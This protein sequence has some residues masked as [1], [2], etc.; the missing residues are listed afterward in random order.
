MPTRLYLQGPIT[1]NSPRLIDHITRGAENATQG[2]G[3]FAFATRTGAETLLYSNEINQ[4]CQHGTFKL[5]VGI[6]S[7]TTDATLDY[8]T[9]QA[10]S[11]KGL[12]V[13]AFNNPSNALFHPKFIHFRASDRHTL[14]SGS[15]NLTQGGLLENFENFTVTRGSPDTMLKV[16]NSIDA[17]LDQHAPYIQ[18]FSASILAKARQNRTA[19]ATTPPTSKPT[20]KTPTPVTTPSSAARVLVAEIPRSGD[21]WRQANFDE[22]TMKSFFQIK[23][24]SQAT[25]YLYLTMIN[26][27][28][29][30]DPVE[31][32]PYVFSSTSQNFRIELGAASGLEYPQRD[33][34]IAVFMEV[35]RRRFYY[36]LV[37]P[38]QPG[39]RSL[40]SIV[41]GGT[42]QMDRL[43]ATTTELASAWPRCP[44]LN[45]VPEDSQF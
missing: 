11:L 38:G 25:Q 19:L 8:L 27:F 1:K 44:L 32:R 21:R 35:G 20:S 41:P 33:R 30:M 4:L 7:I 18:P 3:V 2:T 36:C 24:R 31:V 43:Q 10:A 14:V 39:H 29:Q 28:N 17:F 5:I 26:R 13:F 23:T 15:G 34:P 37:M 22:N 45:V 9:R 40:R 16:S 12:S 42:N 6:D